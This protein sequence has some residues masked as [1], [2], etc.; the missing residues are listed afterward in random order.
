MRNWYQFTSLPLHN[1]GNIFV[2][3][4][5]VFGIQ[6]NMVFV[7]GIRFIQRI[8]PVNIFGIRQGGGCGKIAPALFGGRGV[9]LGIVIILIAW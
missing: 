6:F 8:V 1:I 7:I 4:V 3:D 5:H 2:I 9:S